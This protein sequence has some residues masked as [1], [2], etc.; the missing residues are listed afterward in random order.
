MMEFHKGEFSLSHRSICEPEDEDAEQK[1]CRNVID[2][3]R[4]I[5]GSL[6]SMKYFLDCRWQRRKSVDND[7]LMRTNAEWGL[8]LSSVVG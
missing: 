8:W 4:R 1:L 6:S 5:W 7:W 2:D 3:E